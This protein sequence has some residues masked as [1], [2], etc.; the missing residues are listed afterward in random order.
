MI[1]RYIEAVIKKIKNNYYKLFYRIS[2]NVICQLCGWKGIKF[3]KDKCPKCNS[4]AR[5][6]LIP[7]S[8][9]YFNIPKQVTKILHIAPNEPEFNYINRRF[10]FKKYDRLDIRKYS[11]R[12]KRN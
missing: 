11:S 5:T 2:S 1:K 8:I 4:L 9:D 7:F 12:F 10:A 3:P 6:R